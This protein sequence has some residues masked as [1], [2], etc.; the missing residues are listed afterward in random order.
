MSAD[1]RDPATLY[2]V[3]D[4]EEPLSIL[5]SKGD[6]V[7]AFD[8]AHYVPPSA[9]T[10]QRPSPAE[11]APLTLGHVRSSRDSAPTDGKF[12]PLR[13][14][15]LAAAGISGEELEKLILKMLHTRGAMT[16]RSLS[17]RLG[18]P[19]RLIEPD[20][21]K[22]KNQMLVGYR[23]TAGMG[24]YEYEMSGAGAE[25]ARRYMNVSAYADTAPV[26]LPDYV[27][28][29]TA[30]SP[31]QAGIRVKELEAAFTDLMFDPHMLDRLGPAINSGRGL[32][33]YGSPGN[34]K[35]SISER[36]TNCFG[37]GIWIPRSVTVD[38]EIIRLYD[39]VLHL[40]ISDPTQNVGGAEPIEDLRWI[41]IQRPTVII[42]GEL[43]MDQ[44]EMRHNPTTNVS[45][46]PLQMKSNC[47]VFVIDDFGR[48]RMPTSDLLNRW[49]VPLE[50]RYDFQSLASGKKIQVPFDQL[51]VFS[52]NLEPRDLVDEAFLRRIPYKIEI[53]D[54]EE[55]I[56][57]K[58]FHMVGPGLGFKVTDQIVDWV[59]AEHYHKIDRE[60]RACHPRDLCL[61]ARSWCLYHEKPMELTKENLDF[62]VE[63]YFTVM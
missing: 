25:R 16:G 53:T 56:F 40:P 51:I 14:Q 49:I 28:S 39:P 3:K 10:P 57:R 6:D 50:K 19:Y 5:K 15:T 29:V 44:L 42:G 33:L 17:T 32:F 20:L 26:P 37:S 54:P 1:P 8:E 30:Q 45:E 61:Q 22:L 7:D 41:K 9:P 13:P 24:D 18:L 34:G 21:L 55:A 59:L 60:M 11:E 48:Q 2:K 38:G 62:A 52:T 4:G 58:I 36:I 35:T 47:G 46:A 43:T 23:G 12:L 63:N 31:T 27:A